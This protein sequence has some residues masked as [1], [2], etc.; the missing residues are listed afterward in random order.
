MAGGA[1]N[2]TLSNVMLR[3]VIVED[4][5]LTAVA[6]GRHWCLN[7]VVLTEEVF[8]VPQQCGSKPIGT[9]IG[10][11]IGNFQLQN[12]NGEWFELYEECGQAS[13]LWV[14]ATAGW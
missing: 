13:A 6:D 1:F 5:K 8:V 10:K 12:C 4:D 7:N 11:A 2:A 3:E 14:V 9:V